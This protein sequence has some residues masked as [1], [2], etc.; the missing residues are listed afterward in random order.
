MHHAPAWVAAQAPGPLAAP[1]SGSSGV[2][3]AFASCSGQVEAWDTQSLGCSLECSESI[4]DLEE[5]FAS[6]GLASASPSPVPCSDPAGSDTRLSGLPTAAT[7]APLHAAPTVAAAGPFLYA[8]VLDGLDPVAAAALAEAS[9]RKAREKHRHSFGISGYLQIQPRSTLD[10]YGFYQQGGGMALGGA[11]DPGHFICQ[12]AARSLEQQVWEQERQAR[13][14][15]AAAAALPRFNT[16]ELREANAAISAIC[17]PDL[18]AFVPVHETDCL[19]PLATQHGIP[20]ISIALG[21][22]YFQRLLVRDQNMQAVAKASGF[23]ISTYPTA[24]AAQ[25]Q[26]P[27]AVVMMRSCNMGSPRSDYLLAVYCTCIYL[28]AKVADRVKYK[29]MLSRMLS[30]VV[31]QEVST[32]DATYLESLVLKSLDW[33][34]GPFFDFGSDNSPC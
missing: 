8:P 13:A 12:A 14:A 19:I 32:E 31:A 1:A 15:A 16:A 22:S 27:R 23:F 6:A 2:S 20:P 30:L 10:G 24:P 7:A 25:G 33:R 9:A 29:Q 26:Q 34:L 18:E 11:A 4:G 17:I 21:A 3:S 5:G 28:A